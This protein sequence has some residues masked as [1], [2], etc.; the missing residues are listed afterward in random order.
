M[1]N[2]LSI[3]A[4][5]H[6]RLS[7][8]LK[9]CAI[10]MTVSFVLPYVT[11]AFDAKNYAI[12][13]PHFLRIAHLGKALNI[14]EKIGAIKQGFQG[15]EKTVVCIQDL[16]CNYEVQKNIAGIIRHLVKKHGLKLVGEEG[17][18]DTVNTDKI[19][20][21]PIKKIRE[22]V[23]DYFVKQGKI[24]GA[25][26]YACTSGQD[27]RLE[28]IETPS[29]YQASQKA[30]RSFLNAESQGYCYDLRDILEELKAD[31]YN[32]RLLKFDGKR[33][34]YREGDID[35]LKYSA[36]LHHIARKLRV[37]LS[38]YPNLARFL[39]LKQN[40]F[41]AQ[42]D[43]DH[44]FQEL[45]KLDAAIRQ[46]LY[47]DKTQ[48]E[49]DELYHRLDIVER[50]LNISVTPE[51]LE[52]F[53]AQREKYTTQAFINFINQVETH[54]RASLQHEYLLDPEM[55]VLDEY[56]KQVEDFYR[57]ADERSIHFV[58]NLVRKMDRLDEK[59]A[60][61]INGGF[62]TDKVLAELKRRD[63]TYVSIKPR[64]TRQDVVNPY[65]SLLQG[66]ETPLE[67]LLAKNQTIMGLLTSWYSRF[68]LTN[69][70]LKMKALQTVFKIPEMLM[71]AVNKYIE[72]NTLVEVAALNEE[73]MAE[74]NIPSLENIII[75][76]TSLRTEQGEVLTVVMAPRGLFR[77]KI[78]ASL[79][80]ETTEFTEY[81][82]SIFPTPTQAAVALDSSYQQ[83]TSL[84]FGWL[85]KNLQRWITNP[86][87][88]VSAI[89]GNLAAMQMA[90]AQKGPGKASKRAMSLGGKSELL[91]MW[92]LK[93]FPRLAPHYDNFLVPIETVW[94]IVFG[95]IGLLGWS[96]MH[97]V[98]AQWLSIIVQQWLSII[99]QFLPTD[100]LTT[101]LQ[102][103]FKLAFI[104][105]VLF[106]LDKVFAWSKLDKILPFLRTEPKTLLKNAAIA[107]FISLVTGL[108]WWGIPAFIFPMV[109]LLISLIAFLVFHQ[110]FNQYF[111][112][113]TGLT[114]EK[115]LNEELVRVVINSFIKGKKPFNLID[116]L[117]IIEFAE[118][119]DL[120]DLKSDFI[121]LA[122]VSYK[123]R[124]I[125]SSILLLMKKWGL[126]DKEILAELMEISPDTDIGMIMLVSSLEDLKPSQALPVYKKAL[127]SDDPSIV[128]AA[129]WAIANPESYFARHAGESAAPS[130]GPI[131]DVTVKLII[132]L[133]VKN[134]ILKNG[135][136]STNETSGLAFETLIKLLRSENRDKVKKVFEEMTSEN[137][138]D[139][140]LK[141]LS[142]EFDIIIKKSLES[143]KILR[144]IKHARKHNLQNLK[145]EFIKKA[146]IFY[147]DKKVIN[148]ILSL[149]KKWK[150]TDEEI[151]KE[152][153]AISPDIRVMISLVS[154]LKD[155]KL[156]QTLQV[157]RR[158]LQSDDS[159]I[160]N[161]ALWVIVEKKSYFVRATTGKAAAPPGPIDK[162]TVKLIIELTVKD[163]KFVKGF[164]ETDKHGHRAFRILVKLAESENR[165]KVMEVF[166]EM[167]RGESSVDL[168][169]RRLTKKVSDHIEYLE[170]V[171]SKAESPPVPA[172]RIS[173]AIGRLG[174]MLKLTPSQMGKQEGRAA[175]F[176]SFFPVLH[177]ILKDA[178]TF[179]D[180]GLLIILP[181]VLT[182]AAFIIAHYAGG[183]LQYDSKESKYVSSLTLDK[184]QTVYQRLNLAGKASLTATWSSLLGMAVVGV[185]AAM[186]WLGPMALVALAVLAIPFGG[187]LHERANLP[188]ERENIDYTDTEKYP[189]LAKLYKD[190]KIKPGNGEKPLDGHV[191]GER[192]SEYVDTIFGKKYNL[193]ENVR[194]LI[195]PAFSVSF[196]EIK[197]DAKED[198]TQEYL[199]EKTIFVISM[200]EWLWNIAKKDKNAKWWYGPVHYMLGVRLK[201]SL[202]WL[203]LERRILYKLI[204]WGWDRKGEVVK[205]IVGKSPEVER[206]I[207]PKEDR[208]Q[209]EKDLPI[210]LDAFLQICNQELNVPIAS[211]E[212]S[213]ELSSDLA[214]E[215]MKEEIEAAAKDPEKRKK[216]F[217][218]H[219]YWFQ[220]RQVATMLNAA[221]SRENTLAGMLKQDLLQEEADESLKTKAEQ[222]LLAAIIRGDKVDL[223]YDFAIGDIETLHLQAFPE[224]AKRLLAEEKEAL[225]NSP[226]LK[227]V[228]EEMKNAKPGEIITISVDDQVRKL[229]KKYQRPEK[230][231]EAT[232]SFALGKTAEGD[233]A[234]AIASTNE[235][236]H[237]KVKVKDE[238]EITFYLPIVGQV[239][240]GKDS[241]LVA[242]I[243]RINNQ[244]QAIK[245]FAG[246]D[247]LAQGIV[248]VKNDAKLSASERMWIGISNKLWFGQSRHSS[249]ATAN[250]DGYFNYMVEKLEAAIQSQITT[251]AGETTF[252][253]F[254]TELRRSGSDMQKAVIAVL[255]TANKDKETQFQAQEQLA[256]NLR[257]LITN[258]NKI[259]Q[260]ENIEES[261]DLLAENIFNIEAFSRF[262]ELMDP[263]M[264]VERNYATPD[265]HGALANI[266]KELG[267][268]Q[269]NVSLP[270]I[271]QGHSRGAQGAY[272][273]TLRKNNY[274]VDEE[275]TKKFR[276]KAIK[277]FG[278]AA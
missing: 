60:V 276:R 125:V 267:I 222:A 49:L 241:D 233:S 159:L 32:S 184:D 16:H 230:A 168:R 219:P 277:L 264:V 69:V 245:L 97:L 167:Q 44:L 153:T 133:I 146:T 150:V 82:F 115:K 114:R 158:A 256:H 170:S 30:V 103:M 21:F 83:T 105:P 147:N 59:L 75:L 176:F 94:Y 18:F 123:D 211:K 194:F 31:I 273:D 86:S 129:L 2:T 26:Y 248:G 145:S 110:I 39:S 48:Q 112:S 54:D 15:K 260:L 1:N 208:P 34:A 232:Q 104:L 73:E 179:I 156:S 225:K 231:G 56:L 33:V 88:P 203:S 278:G 121:K 274:I 126:T 221:Q 19:S 84:T 251:K 220:K 209:A 107:A 226:V 139:I 148:A 45:D 124:R 157:L 204:E 155:L 37:N 137:T 101:I 131:D 98:I 68:F 81:F 52:T 263:I 13:Q 43:P 99:A 255:Q 268:R 177:F 142:Q 38:V 17:A 10:L 100:S 111:E 4:F 80:L 183:V 163:A 3:A 102:S 275:N 202:I 193:K 171:E 118:K 178:P 6:P 9:A 152:L 67:K 246:R 238:E 55:H 196:Q 8:Q 252:I 154:E 272:Q 78:L 210:G 7:I 25:E 85:V 253:P 140:G 257:A 35:I 22:E 136:L 93:L 270:Y 92:T 58:D 28:G 186:G 250:P 165:D 161:T 247:S 61:M 12:F 192:L 95:G 229:V 24:T 130:P 79:S 227:I 127:Q 265:K 66:R 216:L 51:E 195:G 185:V 190:M 50:L 116:I 162:E 20:T 182:F 199:K 187:R 174:E 46:Q 122:I 113:G 72:E 212:L 237:Y 149:L 218:D 132:Q 65:F 119:H 181:V 269:T 175:A 87:V 180:F 169:L 160:V 151:L 42:V 223:L 217:K 234:F 117:K 70:E 27:I 106:H 14:P 261:T 200:P 249:V 197:P 76:S 164:L 36:Y 266:I 254:I 262:A 62:H 134:S 41:S 74:Y 143:F 214:D 172:A 213:T 239:R 96:G 109:R 206:T 189:T 271:L 141:I 201:L 259:F 89:L 244:K 224:M 242:A 11:W 236:E 90:Q 23:S 71:P 77:E 173:G 53:R 228:L 243:K 57:L 63:I 207:G 128:N 198:I 188:Y 40:F 138:E 235:L 215:K 258:Y 120:K 91:K 29:L 205:Y 166:A 191:I 240:V 64:V 47:T 144:K 5:R 135:I 108:V